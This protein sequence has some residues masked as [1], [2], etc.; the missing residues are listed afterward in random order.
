M[1]YY[2]TTF[3]RSCFNFGGEIKQSFDVV[4]F[5]KEN[6]Y[7]DEHYHKFN[8]A[9]CVAAALQ[10]PTSDPM[11]SWLPLDS[12]WSSMLG[13]SKF[14]KLDIPWLDWKIRKPKPGKPVIACVYKT[15]DVDVCGEPRRYRA[16]GFYTLLKKK[17]GVTDPVMLDV[18]PGLAKPR[19]Y[20]VPCDPKDALIVSGSGIAGNLSLISE[21]EVGDLVQWSDIMIK[22]EQYQYNQ[23]VKKYLENPVDFDFMTGR[24]IAKHYLKGWLEKLGLTP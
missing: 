11:K 2:K 4:F 18:F 21:I 12:G 15:K 6:E 19:W 5:R 24:D 10:I 22:Q 1:P 23:S 16:T 3:Y 20:V 14:I 13:G 8:D 9:A 17:S 7:T